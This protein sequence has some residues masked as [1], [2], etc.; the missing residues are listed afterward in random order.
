MAL[1]PVAK[2]CSRSP[3]IAVNDQSSKVAHDGDRVD[4]TQN[5]VCENA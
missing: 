5:A 3:A 4:G 2:N 1:A